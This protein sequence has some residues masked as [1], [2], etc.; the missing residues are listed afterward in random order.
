MQTAD[1]Q[2]TVSLTNLGIAKDPRIN[3]NSLVVFYLYKRK[4]YS[5]N[6]KSAKDKTKCEDQLIFKNEK[7]EAMGFT[8]EPGY[9]GYDPNRGSYFPELTAAPGQ[10]YPTIKPA[11]PPGFPNPDSWQCIRNPVSSSPNLGKFECGINA[12]PIRYFDK[13]LTTY[14]MGVYA[15]T[16]HG[17]PA[18]YGSEYNLF[19]S[20]Y[21]PVKDGDRYYGYFAVYFSATRNAT[22]AE[23]RFELGS[24]AFKRP[25]EPDLISPRVEITVNLQATGKIPPG[26][27]YE[28]PD[29]TSWYDP[30]S[31]CRSTQ[32][33][34]L[35][36][37]YFSEIL[38]MGSKDIAG[39]GS[40]EDEFIEIYNSNSYDVVLSGWRINGAGSGSA[41]I[42]LPSCSLIKA[43]GT[44][45][46]AKQTSKAFGKP[47]YTDAGL[48]LSNLGEA[49]LSI[50]DAAG[51][52]V[53]SMTGCTT[54]AWGGQGVLGGSGN[55]NRSMRLVN[56]LAPSG[57][58]SSGWVTTSTADAGYGSA[59]QNLAVSFKATTDSGV[60][61]TVATPGFK[62][63]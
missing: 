47:D 17:M 16:Q 42:S 35:N 13:D 10:N 60:D 14:T 43:G 57:N 53:T 39:T 31:A 20:S 32:I 21:H 44:Y 49:K 5:I 26:S 50:Q 58:C 36:S 30:F 28:I 63:P 15:A 4:D 55:A 6:C 37:V 19:M 18:P 3:P 33:V 48:S 29:Y 45:T 9:F 41:S 34:P 22:D 7:I 51:N 27:T 1:G 8:N 59:S 52:I 24:A 61:G 38:W 62:G 54:P 56:V 11:D 23:E 2:I 40:A 12:H 25:I 46:V